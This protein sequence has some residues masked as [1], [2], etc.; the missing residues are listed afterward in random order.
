MGERNVLMT[1]TT[2]TTT[3]TMMMMMMMIMM[4][5]TT[6]TKTTIL[7][8]PHWCNAGSNRG[9]RNHLKIICKTPVQHTGK[10]RNHVTA[11]NNHIGHC[12]HTVES[13]DVKY[14]SFNMGNN[15]AYRINCK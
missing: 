9:N 5:M 11:E 15:I 7:V 2:T 3:T 10:S 6:T 12:T 4:M 14:E 8:A 1:T 13:A